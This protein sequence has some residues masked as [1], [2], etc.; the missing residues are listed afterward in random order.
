M[1]WLNWMHEGYQQ[2]ALVRSKGQGADV[3]LGLRPDEIS[4]GTE[5]QS[6]AVKARVLVTEPLG[7]DMLVDVALGD[8]KLLVK[9]KPDFQADMPPRPAVVA[10]TRRGGGKIGT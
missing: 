2:A 10:I 1:A 5:P 7:G 3:R 4:I 8:T 6:G 9:T